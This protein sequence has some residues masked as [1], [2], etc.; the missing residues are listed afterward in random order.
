VDI[1]V[2]DTT[3]HGPVYDQVRSQI[4]GLIE[5]GKLAAGESL[6]N[7]AVLARDIK[8]DRGEVS[9]A[10]FELEQMGL[11]VVKKSKNFLG[12]ATTMY[13]VR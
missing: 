3:V 11:V 7:P 13:S 12:E 8:V 6:P 10:Y 9:R 2:G 5:S 1:K 4:A